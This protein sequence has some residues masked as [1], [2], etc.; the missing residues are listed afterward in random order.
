MVGWS[1]L[2]VGGNTYGNETL[3]MNIVVCK[4]QL[5]TRVNMTVSTSTTPATPAANKENLVSR[6]R[7]PTPQSLDR[8]HRP[9]KCPGSATRTVATDRPA[10]KRRRVDYGGADGEADADKPY[11][12]ADRLALANRDANRFPVFKA[13]DKDT[14]FRKAFSVPFVNKDNAAY[15]PN[16]PPPTLGLRQGA[17]FVAKPLH[18]P[19]GEF[20]IVLH[21]PTVDD[22]PK[23]TSTPEEK[24]KEAEAPPKLDAPLM[25]KSLAEILGIKKK[26]EGEHPRVPV[27]IDPRLAKVL[28]PHLD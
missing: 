6:S 18:D 10:R 24:Q 13:K 26:V 9:F 25:H 1:H 14:I 2:P 5:N 23:E 12:N 7:F 20:A 27:V 8:L 15:N 4:G 21:D 19:C 22:K 17:V 3:W 11:T 16:R 28:R